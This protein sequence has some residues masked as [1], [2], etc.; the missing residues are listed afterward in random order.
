MT[1][2]HTPRHSAHEDDETTVIPAIKDDD[3]AYLPKQTDPPPAPRPAPA[4]PIAVVA[5]PSKVD[6]SMSD[7]TVVGLTP[8][9]GEADTA[10]IPKVPAAA[11]DQPTPRRAR[12]VART[13]SR[14]AGEL[15]V[16]FGLVV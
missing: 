5:A 2:P 3:T 13:V 7:D 10:I 6:L 16:T 8:V 1:R 14:G 9:V 12:D 4:S 11:A 15:L